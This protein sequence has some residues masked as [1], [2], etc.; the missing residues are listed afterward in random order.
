MTPERAKELLPIIQA[1][2]DGED[3][4]CGSSSNNHWSDLNKRAHFEDDLEYRIK[5][6]PREFWVNPDKMTVWSSDG[7]DCIHVREVLNEERS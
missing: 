6:E 1:F 4:Q 7:H 5:P 3:I 2:A